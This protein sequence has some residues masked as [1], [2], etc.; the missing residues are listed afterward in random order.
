MTSFTDASKELAP[1]AKAAK[2]CGILAICLG[3]TCIGIPAAI[4]L[5]IV[6]LVQHQKAKHAAAAE[7]ER[8]APVPATGL[9]TGIIGLVMPIVMLPFIGIVSAIAIPA[10]LGQRERART[11]AVDA[12]VAQ[13]AL[14]IITE[15]GTGAGTPDPEV[16]VRKV[17]SQPAFTLPEAKNVY[18]PETCA[19]L[20]ASE[21]TRDGQVALLGGHRVLEDGRQQT[22]VQIQ[23]QVRRGQTSERITKIVELD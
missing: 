21:P 16:L 10:L 5:G 2:T 3:L 19:F 15:A 22:I 20:A 17:L 8:F 13:A 9:V 14:A 7:P 12:Q 23:G 1:G 18:A 11:H 6:A 4:I